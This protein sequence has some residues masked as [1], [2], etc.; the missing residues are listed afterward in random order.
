MA[1]V[2]A[3]PLEPAEVI[4]VA[5]DTDGV[6]ALEAADLVRSGIASRVAVFVDSSNATVEEEFRRRGITYEGPSA[7]TI[8]QLRALG[9]DSVERVPGFVAGSEDEGPV[10]ATWCDQQ[11]FHSV[12]VVS[13]ADHTRR[14]RRMLQRSMKGHVTRVAVRGSRYSSFQPEHWWESHDG[15]RTE[16][17]EVEKLLLDV[18]R[19]PMS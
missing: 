8:E 6:G 13:T 5:I 19:H 11:R 7:R 10:L 1:L 14:L 17:E 9:I 18:V 16:L 12:L 2:A 4:V 15:T 3:D